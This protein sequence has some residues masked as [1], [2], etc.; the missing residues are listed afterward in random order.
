M[1]GINA[2]SGKI[3]LL[4]DG[5]Y[6]ALAAV[7]PKKVHKAVSWQGT[8]LGRVGRTRQDVARDFL[9][10]VAVFAAVKNS[11]KIL[12]FTI[13]A[14]LRPL[15]VGQQSAALNVGV[16]GVCLAVVDFFGQNKG[17][18]HLD[19]VSGGKILKRPDAE[20]VASV[21]GCIELGLNVGASSRSTRNASGISP[22]GILV[23]ALGHFNVSLVVGG[24][25]EVQSL[26]G[27]VEDPSLKM[28]L[29]P[30]DLG[31]VK[32]IF[33]FGSQKFLA[34]VG[35][36][37]ARISRC[38]KAVCQVQAVVVAIAAPLV[39]HGSPRPGRR[40]VDVANYFIGPNRSVNVVVGFLTHVFEGSID[41][42]KKIAKAIVP[43]V[44]SHRHGDPHGSEVAANGDCG[45]RNQNVRIDGGCGEVLVRHGGGSVVGVVLE[46]RR[47]AK[48]RCRS[49]F[50]SATA[51]GVALRSIVGR[52]T[53]PNS[54]ARINATNP[55]S[56]FKKVLGA[57][58]GGVLTGWGSCS[59]AVAAK[60]V[61]EGSDV[62]H[63]HAHLACRGAS[64]LERL[65]PG[66]L[67]QY[68]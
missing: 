2:V 35:V 66:A 45:S 44:G 51:W 7:G 68:G 29:E 54:T 42:H 47:F 13:V 1:A 8:H 20:Q 62:G 55:N 67:P 31:V 27:V 23:E 58:A 63:A 16:Y 14:G 43:V 48:A 49:K 56:R 12:V 40:A 30:V 17:K 41:H 6:A 5:V 52:G 19:F 22:A 25:E 9:V 18:G 46:R 36:G 39:E 60:G 34:D 37:P 4:A 53:H 64:F 32:A 50:K 15:R 10:A 11:V 65:R 24:R 26:P 59:V 3:L 61:A 57:R 28:V 21:A 33:V 38:I